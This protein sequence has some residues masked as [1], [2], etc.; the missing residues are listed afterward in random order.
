ML[1][2]KSRYLSWRG[3][4]FSVYS[5]RTFSGRCAYVL[6]VLVVLLVL[7]VLLVVLLLVLVDG[8]GEIVG[9]G[10]GLIWTP[11]IYVVRPKWA[12]TPLKRDGTRKTRFYNQ[13]ETEY[14][15]LALPRVG[16]ATD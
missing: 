15:S 6:A 4:R 1:L 16:H 3:W 5:S 11:S 14:T 2:Y 8:G 9:P 12:P 10:R 7:L 13:A